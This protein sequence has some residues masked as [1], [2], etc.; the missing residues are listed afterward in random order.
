MFER[1][2]RLHIKL[3]LTIAGANALLALVAFGVFSRSFDEGFVEYLNQADEARLA[4]FVAQLAEAHREDGN[5]QRFTED[6]R[7]WVELA[8]E[9]LGTP[10]GASQ[11]PL[12]TIDPRLLLFDA[13]RE[14]L[15][16]RPEMADEA[17]LRAIEVDGRTVGHLGFVPRLRMVESLEKL[18]SAQQQRRYAAIATGMLAAALL[19]GALIAWWLSRRVRRLGLGAAALI[20]GD[21][22][23]RVSVDGHDELARL[24]GDLNRLAETLAAARSARQRWIGDIAHELRTPLATLRAEIEAL[25]DGVRALDAASLSS[26]AQEVGQLTR[27][28]EDLHMLS[29]SDLGALSYR[30]EPVDLGELIDEVVQ[31]H[32]HRLAEHGI[33]AQ[34]ELQEGARVFA[35]QARL[36]QVFANLLQNT[37]RYTD[38]P[39]RLKVALSC[40]AGRAA[41]CWDDSAP[42]VA[43]QD[44]PRLTDR[45]FRLD[46]S[47]SRAGGGTGLG[48]AIAEAIVAAHGGSMKASASELGG[49]RWTIELPLH[50]ASA[51]V[52]ASVPAAS[53]TVPVPPLVRLSGSAAVPASTGTTP[54]NAAGNGGRH[55]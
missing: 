19:V 51:P 33:E 22:D 11:G 54:P 15:I 16:G 8:R 50:G 47:R 43:A 55:G 28:V 31:L 20:R 21:Y 5:W 30:M 32:R 34:T 46:A 42:G 25:E 14:L 26:L 37:V 1:F 17:Q 45:L 3:F 29:M 39:G 49:L 44:L 48:L 13:N 35:D 40:R 24:A 9:V 2:D 4:P 23:A 18:F 53:G 41:V 12:L 52:P 27:L 10:R 7:R 6:R 38:S 36:T